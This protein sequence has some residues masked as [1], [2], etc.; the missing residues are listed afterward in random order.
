[1]AIGESLSLEQ[2]MGGG[3]EEEEERNQ[4]G[5]EVV[6]TSLT[7]SGVVHG[8]HIMFVRRDSFQSTFKGKEISLHLLKKLMLSVCRH[9]LK[10][11]HQ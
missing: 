11:P 1:M 5:E 8:S 6:M 3:M 9:I 10:P 2:V 4:W 7:R